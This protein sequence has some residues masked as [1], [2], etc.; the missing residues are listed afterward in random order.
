VDEFVANNMDIG[1]VDFDDMSVC[2]WEYFGQQYNLQY[3]AN[4]YDDN[5]G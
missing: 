3:R 4:K 1:D 5:F 2:H